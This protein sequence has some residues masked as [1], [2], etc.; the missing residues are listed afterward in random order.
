MPSGVLDSSFGTSGQTTFSF[1]TGSDRPTALAIQPDGKILVVGTCP[2]ALAN[3]DFCMIRVNPN[4]ESLDTSF[5]VD[6]LNAK[7][8]GSGYDNPS[9]IALLPDG[10]FV[11]A[12]FCAVGADN[13][14]CAA[15]FNPD[16]S[17]DSSFDGDGRILHPI[18]GTFDDGWALALQPDGKVVIAGGCF[19]GGLSKFCAI[20]LNAN[21]SLDTSFDG[22][23]K[24]IVSFGAFS[25][26][27]A[28]GV[29]TQ[30]DGKIVL[31][32]SCSGAGYDF[33]VAR[34]ND[35]GSLDQSFSGDGL[36]TAPVDP[37]TG[38][39]NVTGL[40]LQSDGKILLTGYCGSGVANDFCFAR[41]QGDA[42]G[43]RS[44]SMDIDGDGVVL[45]TTDLLIATRVAR[46]MVGSDV[47][48]GLNFAVSATRTSWAEI[49]NFLVASC[50]M[51]V[52]P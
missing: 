40:A 49:R 50:G 28:R 45:P 52:Q 24:V 6:G 1:S 15:R 42:N 36:Q 23:G 5:G 35:D 46:G 14:F 2:G 39:D 18:A 51:A 21:G 43:E 3:G 32:G 27:Y 38:N 19:V 16:G 13:Q 37:F 25:D 12:G 8:I 10:R 31:G 34:L 47:I 9:A 29:A 41:F 20:R 4:G 26:A 7:A 33:C 17:L 44:C 48:R 22:D 30:P 11:V